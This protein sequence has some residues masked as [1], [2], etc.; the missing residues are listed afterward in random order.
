MEV[1]PS[2]SCAP[3]AEVTPLEWSMCCWRKRATVTEEEPHPLFS[4][5]SC[6]SRPSHEEEEN[7]R[8]RYCGRA[9]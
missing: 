9:P 2:C 3:P 7:T 1:V 4:W 6:S 5:L 8:R